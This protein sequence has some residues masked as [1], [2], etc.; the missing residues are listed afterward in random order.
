MLRQL[1]SGLALA[2]TCLGLAGCWAGAAAVA[3]DVA[4]VKRTEQKHDF[5]HAVKEGYAKYQ[6]DFESIDC[7]RQQ[8]RISPEIIEFVKN[9]PPHGLDQAI[10]LLLDIYN[11]KTQTAEVRSHALYHVSVAYMRRRESNLDLAKGYLLTIK[12]EFPGT[13]DC[14]IAYLLEEIKERKAYQEQM[15]ALEDE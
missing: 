2:L 7:P 13:H 3:T 11:D 6:E 4:I 9:R 5:V 1:L 12:E 14:V 10:E 8:Y 15:D